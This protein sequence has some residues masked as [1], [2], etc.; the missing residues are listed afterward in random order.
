MDETICVILKLLFDFALEVW[1]SILK[2]SCRCFVHFIF[3]QMP[4]Q[5][6]DFIG[7]ATQPDNNT[8]NVSMR[9]AKT[10]ISI[11]IHTF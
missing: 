3:V 2:F 10:K 1:F 5:Q 4:K 6:L 7:V 11:G 9:P 8:N